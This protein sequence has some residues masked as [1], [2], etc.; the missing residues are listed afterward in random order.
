MAYECDVKDLSAQPT[1]AIRTRTSVQELSRVLGEAYGAIAQYIGEL[2]EQFAGPPYVAY[3]NEDME[4]LDLEIGFPVTRELPGEGDIQASEIPAG[5]VATCLHTG[6]YSDVEP[7]YNALG[8]WIEENGY[9]PTG[10]AYEMYPNDPDETPTE[11]LQ[12][13]IM[14]PVRS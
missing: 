1:L 5:K 11:E 2:G 4:D 7:A 9:E 3:Y 8:H 6:P 10:V 13:Q 12:T 14:F